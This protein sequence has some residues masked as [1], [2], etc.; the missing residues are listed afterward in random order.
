M[1]LALLI[2]ASPWLEMSGGPVFVGHGAAGGS[3]G[4]MARIDVGFPVA[5]RFAVEGW[6]S[7]YMS[8]TSRAPGDTAVMSLGAG[9][10]FL[11]ANFGAQTGL[12]AHAG[13]G[14]APYVGYGGRS[15]PTA[16]AGALLSFQ[17][18]L[19]RFSLGVEADAYVFSNILG[20]GSAVGVA[21]LPY[22]RCSF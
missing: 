11:M 14:Y 13:G 20:P 5:E 22:L 12:W 10:R 21:V 6:M 18:F 16:F 7:G 19:K 17:P 2:A 9:A 4:P 15:G 3:N 1:L 8:G